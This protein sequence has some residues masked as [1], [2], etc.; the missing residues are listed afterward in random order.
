MVQQY[1]SVP[2]TPLLYRV[3]LVTVLAILS[4]LTTILSSGQYYKISSMLNHMKIDNPKPTLNV[5]S[6]FYAQSIA[7]TL[8]KSIHDKV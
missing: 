3:L 4:Q 6:V 1:H 7:K 8:L 5:L 2:N